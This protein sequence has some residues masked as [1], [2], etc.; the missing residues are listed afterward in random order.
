MCAARNVKLKK[1]ESMT[2]KDLPK[3]WRSPLAPPETEQEAVSWAE[4]QGAD[5]LYYYERHRKKLW[6]IEGQ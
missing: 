3:S 2:K 1:I 6:L 4:E 5:V